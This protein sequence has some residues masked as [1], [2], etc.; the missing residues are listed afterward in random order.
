MRYSPAPVMPKLSCA[1]CLVAAWGCGSVSS[2]APDAGEGGAGGPPTDGSPA[3]SCDPTAAFGTP[4]PVAGLASRS[5]A[6][7]FARLT[8]DEL[9]VYFS[10]QPLTTDAQADI[11]TAHRG[12]ITEAFGQ[13]TQV[14]RQNSVLD[15]FDP[16]ISADGLALWF[17]TNRDTAPNP[18]RRIYGATRATTTA[19]FGDPHAATA[20][21][22]SDPA[23]VD[24]EPFQTADG[25]Q[26]W[27]SSNRDHGTGNQ[28]IWYSVATTG[29]FATPTNAGAIN[30]AT[31]DQA[32]VLTAD[33]LTLYYTTD[34]SMT[35][36]E[37]WVSHRGATTD[38]FA[39]PASVPE[40]DLAAATYASWISPDNCRIYLWSD[41]DGDAD[42]FMAERQP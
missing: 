5:A 34:R 22:S 26:L 3:A 10:S 19:D 32:P 21:N 1:L 30:T 4:K 15:E 13:A 35:R 12:S 16:M 27:F 31:D 37:I 11:Y 24:M 42:I 40:L 41:P 20:I 7:I 2:I 28:D 29:G 18:G 14:A 9:T 23:G 25:N 8:P 6:E 39:A 17:S 38:S 36:S 33:G